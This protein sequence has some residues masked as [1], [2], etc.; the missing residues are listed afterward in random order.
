MARW[1][2]NNRHSFL[3]VLEL[4]AQSQGA[5]LCQCFHGGGGGVGVRVLGGVSDRSLILEGST[6][7]TEV[8]PKGPITQDLHGGHWDL[9]TGPRRNT[10]TWSGAQGG[11][12]PDSCSGSILC[13]G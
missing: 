3:V 10:D 11:S 6:L 12:F 7:T 9:N 5:D 4:E 2:M 1:L 13:L 8:S